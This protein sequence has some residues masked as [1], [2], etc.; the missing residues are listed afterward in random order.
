MNP[1]SNNP[2]N[3]SQYQTISTPLIIDLKMSILQRWDNAIVE[4][5]KYKKLKSI[6]AGADKRGV[7][8][9]VYTLF[10][11]VK[12]SLRASKKPDEFEKIEKVFKGDNI[13]EY[14]ETFSLI[15]NF[16]YDKNI[17]KFDMKGNYN[18]ANVEASNTHKGL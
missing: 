7:I 5:G 2:V 14:I 12:S 8:S 3:N 6:G 16:L 9:S 15:D 4:I 18:R 10:M 1:I 11:T 17:V 13:E